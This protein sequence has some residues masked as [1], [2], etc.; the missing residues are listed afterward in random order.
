MAKSPTDFTVRGRGAFPL[1]MLRYDAAYPASSPDALVIE[2]TFR[3]RL[4]GFTSVWTVHLQTRSE[5]GPTPGRW[6]SF[7][8][9]IGPHEEVVI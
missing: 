6:Q 4:E 3:E 2:K 7:G 5:I 9:Q 8:W 1:D